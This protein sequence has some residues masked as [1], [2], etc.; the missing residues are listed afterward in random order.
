MTFQIN[1]HTHSTLP[2]TTLL[3]PPDGIEGE[4]GS[5]KKKEHPIGGHQFVAENI[6]D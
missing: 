3:P 1:I 5:D 6:R 2:P 4:L